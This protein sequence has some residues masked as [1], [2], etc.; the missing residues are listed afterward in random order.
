MKICSS[1]EV[2]ENVVITGFKI[3][4]N[5]LYGII[6]NEGGGDC[7]FATIRDGLS[8]ID[9]NTTVEKLRNIIV[10]KQMKQFIKIS[11]SNMTCLK[12]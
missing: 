8:G 10:K 4:E 9:I 3:Y 1:E 5:S 11:K 7:L 12:Q 2:S 6:D